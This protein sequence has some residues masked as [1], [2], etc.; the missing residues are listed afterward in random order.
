MHDSSACPVCRGLPVNGSL[1]DDEFASF[2]ARC[3]EELARKQ[4]TF[5][6][7]I[8]AGGKWFYDM[9]DGSLTIGATRF[10]M[11]PIGTYSHDRQTWL[12]AW[13]N[14]D[15]P[16]RARDDAG[17]VRGLLDVTGFRVF[18][19]PGLPASE[20]DTLDLTAL[21]VHHLDAIGFFRCPG[22]PTLF[23]AVHEPASVFTPAG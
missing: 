4:A 7:R 19:S 16:Q 8:P 17:R 1:S 15:F 18:V 6:R 2:V 5:N 10:G 21:A 3:R 14:E 22:A 13:A 9:Q 20:A 23:L 11:T 12:W